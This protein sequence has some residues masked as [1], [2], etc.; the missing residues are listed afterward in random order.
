MA[1]GRLR[2]K[3]KE[4]GSFRQFIQISGKKKIFIPAVF[5]LDESFHDKE[6]EYE[7]D[8]NGIQW[9]K[10]GGKEIVKDEAAVSER[11]NK[12]K[13]AEIKRKQEAEAKRKE[14]A[15]ARKPRT[16][17][18]QPRQTSQQRDFNIAERSKLPRDSRELLKD[19]QDQI[20]NLSLRIQKGANFWEDNKRKATLYQEKRGSRRN[21]IPPKLM[22]HLPE[23][24][25]NYG[26]LPFRDLASQTT[27][28]AKLLYGE[29]NVKHP[30]FNTDG[31]L[32][33]GI[34]GASVFEVGIT[35]HHVYGIPYIPASSI[36]G[37]CRS[38]MIQNQYDGSEAKALQNKEFCDLFGCPAEWKDNEKRTHKS[39]Y[40]L[41]KKS[42][43][44]SGDRKGNIIFFDAFP[45]IAPRVEEDVMNVHYPKYYQGESA[46]TDFQSPNPISFMAV[47][48]ATPFQFVL[49]VKN[50]PEKVEISFADL[51]T[52]AEELLSE[53]LTSHGIGAKTAIGYGFFEPA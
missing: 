16:G 15:E 22:K 49:A 53:A 17:G 34:G 10:V 39:W 23:G 33:I 5:I 37:L 51:L 30:A 45:T 19:I 42:G 32:I 7:T 2:I 52:K 18:H 27:H 48:H 43:K 14:A 31:R 50:N 1:T 12:R 26:G 44:D 40:E 25:I 38:W 9:I 8:Q 36:K 20:D 24:E 41:N 28:T 11:E 6:C 13:E 29:N 47:A 4:D 21:N 35:L 3:Q 46:P